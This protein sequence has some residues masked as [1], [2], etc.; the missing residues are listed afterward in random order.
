MISHSQTQG[1]NRRVDWMREYI[2]SERPQRTQSSMTND[3]IAVDRF[4][5]Q[6]P[7]LKPFLEA[8][9]EASFARRVSDSHTTTA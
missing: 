3:S 6:Q 1:T 4:V 7:I 2:K 8:T 5:Y 9:N